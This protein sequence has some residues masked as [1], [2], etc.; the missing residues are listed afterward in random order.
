ML[1]HYTTAIILDIE[2]RDDLDRVI[3]LY[4]KDFGRIKA[5]A[6][7][8]KKITSK[9]AGHLMSGNIVSIRLIERGEGGNFQILDALSERP[10][11]ISLELMK[12]L[13][14][15]NKVSP[16][17]LPDL[18]LWYESE[19]A[20]SQDDFG[21]ARYRRILADLGIDIDSAVCAECG[22]PHV[23][24]FV[25]GDVTFLCADSVKKLKVIEHE[26]VRI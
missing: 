25:P 2:D 10:P 11:R 21:P 26:I 15:L 7:S 8:I 5:R 17:G 9:L 22:D 3:T 16:L 24:Y 13:D 12:F 20:I 14:V 4:T 1:E 6:K 23:A 19:R 18:G